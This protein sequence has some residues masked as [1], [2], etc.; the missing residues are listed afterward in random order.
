MKVH[1]TSQYDRGTATLMMLAMIGILS[2][3]CLNNSRT[4]RQAHDELRLLEKKQI[5]RIQRDLPQHGSK[6]PSFRQK[7]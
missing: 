7:L 4:I 5:K 6:S 1:R 3:L 2:I